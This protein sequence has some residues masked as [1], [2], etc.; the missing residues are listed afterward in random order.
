MNHDNILAH[1]QMCFDCLAPNNTYSCTIPSGQTSCFVSLVSGTGGVKSVTFTGNNVSPTPATE[2]ATVHGIWAYFAGATSST[3]DYLKVYA[4]DVTNG[5]LSYLKDTNFPGDASGIGANA[6]MFNQD[7]KTLYVGLSYN[8]VPSTRVY[9]VDPVT[10]DLTEIQSLTSSTA[11]Q[12]IS[13]GNNVMVLLAGG[14]LYSYTV[15][16][17]DAKLTEVGYKNLNT[18]GYDRGCGSVSVSPDKQYLY[19]TCATAPNLPNFTSYVVAYPIDSTTAVIGSQASYTFANS[20]YNVANY[21]MA[22]ATVVSPDGSK[23]YVTSNDQKIYAYDITSGALSNPV[24]TT[25]A[26]GGVTGFANARLLVKTPDGNA[27]ELIRAITS[28]SYSNSLLT[29]GIQTYSTPLTLVNN[30]GTNPANGA[31]FDPSGKYFYTAS[32]VAGNLSNNQIF[33][34][35]YNSNTGAFAPLTPES[36]STNFSSFIRPAIAISGT[37]NY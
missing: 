10:S 5:K 29:I 7:S 26:I 6:M 8:S 20:A 1:L 23:L 21:K 34:Y 33:Q 36:I 2:D 30:L 32:F 11:T 22:Q 15:D 27:I 9:T 19:L 24:D 37:G 25:T 14:V 16:Q 18:E 3:A 17:S 28:G 31:I 13:V 12:W 35:G 4:L